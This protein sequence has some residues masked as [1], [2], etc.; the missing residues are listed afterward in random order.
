MRPGDMMNAGLRTNNIHPEPG[1][2]ECRMFPKL[3]GTF[4]AANT[5]V[6]PPT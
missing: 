4:A 6:N 2:L 5:P 1:P 3:G